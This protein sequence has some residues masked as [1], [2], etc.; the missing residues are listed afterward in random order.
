MKEIELR[1]V[2]S[3]DAVE[4]REEDGNARIE[5]VAIVFDKETVLREGSDYRE[6][7]VID[8]SCCND[9][10]LRSQDIKLNICHD[11]KTTFGRCNNG[12]GNLQVFA[13]EDGLHFE[14]AGDSEFFKQAST[15][16]RERVYT[17]CSFEFMPGKS[18]VDYR[19]SEREGKDGKTEYVI[20]HTA[21]KNISA[22]TV[23]MDPAYKETKVS[24]REL[25]ME[26][27][28]EPVQEE[29]RE[30]TPEQEAEEARIAAAKREIEIRSRKISHM[31]RTMDMLNV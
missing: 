15:L 27:H 18:G 12:V 13:R 5:G 20:R 16:I 29:V 25:Y 14:C 28:Q 19:V 26:Q 24:V 3:P 2:F 21:F 4:F 6:V 7:E 1:E 17:G 9:E 22:L 30:K 11:R 10:F 31:R 23:A 8:R